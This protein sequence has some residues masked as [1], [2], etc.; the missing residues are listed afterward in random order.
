MV[1]DLLLADCISVV[2]TEKSTEKMGSVAMPCSSTLDRR[3][4]LSSITAAGLASLLAPSAQAAPLLTRRIS[5]TGEALPIVGLGSW[6]TFNVGDDPEGRSA[7]A[8]VM[9]AFFAARGRLIDSSPMYGSSQA[10][11]GDG[12]RRLGRPSQLFSASK[13]WTSSGPD[14]RAQIEESRRL[15]DV[16]RFDLMQVHNLLSW[17]EHLPTLFAMKKRRQLRYVG[18]TTSH[19]RRHDELEEIMASQPIDFIQVTYNMRDR[20][21]ERRILPLALKRRIAVI[22]NRPYD[23]G[24]LIDDVKRS[25]LPAWAAQAGCPTWAQFTLKYILAHPAVTCAIPA[26]SKVAHVRENMGA[27]YGRLPDAE[28]R[29]RMLAY[30]ESL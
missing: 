11:I 28:T 12:I 23:G 7:C 14:G 6:V 16:P 20:E 4:L 30:V 8:A 26:T 22:I 17:E 27:A 21:V 24:A 5:S 25:P 3:T 1:R 10:V 18:V 13:V 9:S 2:A 29:R 19:G 15:W